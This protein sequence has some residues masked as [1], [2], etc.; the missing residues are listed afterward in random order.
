MDCSLKLTGGSVV[1]GSGGPAFAADVAISGDRIVAIGDLSDV[2]AARTLDCRGKTVTPGFIDIHSHADWLLIDPQHHNLVEAFVRQGMTTVVGGNCGFSPAPVSDTNLGGI[3]EASRLIVDAPVTPRWQTMA[4]FLDAVDEVG[5]ALNLAE[6]LGHGSVR[7]AV[8]GSLRPDPPSHD[9]LAQMERLAREALDAGC[10]GIST[11][12]GYPPGIFAEH[13]ELAAFASWAASAGKLFTS[14][15]KAYSRASGV[16]QVDPGEQPH[17]LLAIREIIDAARTGGARL[18]VS[19]LI[20]V[21][22]NTW[23]TCDDAIA[24][25]EAARREG[26]DVA[27]DAFPY[28]AGNTTASV[29]FPP[30]LLPHLEQVLASPEQMEPL[31]AFGDATFERIGFH[32]RDIQIMHANAEAFDRYDGMFVGEAAEAA[33]MDIWDFY[34]RLVVESNR[35]ARVLIHKY[36]GSDDDQRAIETVVAHPLCTVETDTFLTAT[37]HQN[38]ASYGTF[39]RVLSTY[40]DRGLLS[41]EEAVHKMTAASADRIGLG[42]RGRIAEGAAADVVVLDR[43]VLADTATFDAPANYPEGIETVIVNGRPVLDGG[44]YDSEAQAGRVLRN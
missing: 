4:E 41:F 33:G 20:F 6:L 32:L 28:T 35:N 12:L 17:N 31:R 44:C 19:H 15:V 10:I 18:Q 25:I 3:K 1:D 16:Y 38:P 13:D 40:V 21:G 30:E 23:P 11:G 26:L 34:A 43:N 14:H 7:A 36:S 9:E 24:M 39:P 8:T 29:I 27:F 42:D 22:R 37:G 5:P 2:D